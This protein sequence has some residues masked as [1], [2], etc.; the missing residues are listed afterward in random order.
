MKNLTLLWI[1]PFLLA[2]AWF[3][4]HVAAGNLPLEGLVPGLQDSPGTRNLIVLGVL[5]VATL[6]V[7]K[8]FKKKSVEN[9]P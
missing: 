9:K 8:S 1:F 3:H 2:L 7:V 4:H 5:V 6:L